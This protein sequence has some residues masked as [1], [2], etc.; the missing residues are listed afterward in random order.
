MLVLAYDLLLYISTSLTDCGIIIFCALD[1]SAASCRWRW[2]TV[3]LPV[4][5]NSN[6]QSHASFSHFAGCP[7]TTLH[8]PAMSFLNWL[9]VNGTVITKSTQAASWRGM[10]RIPLISSCT[11]FYA[12]PR[13]LETAQHLGH[14]GQTANTI[15]EVRPLDCCIAPSVRLARDRMRTNSFYHM[16]PCDQR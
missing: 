12:K 16:A 10:L 9:S 7:L 13:I 11:L 14:V 2:E 3:T 15:I 4:G 8:Q 1:F 6:P 5:Q